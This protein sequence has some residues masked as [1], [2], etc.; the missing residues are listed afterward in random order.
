MPT[1]TEQV[2]ENGDALVT[3]EEAMTPDKD[4]LQEQHTE[5]PKAEAGSIPVVEPLLGEQDQPVDED[6]E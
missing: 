2:E 6:G 5:K 4:R 1:I 3:R